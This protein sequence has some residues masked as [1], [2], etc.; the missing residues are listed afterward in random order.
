MPF[1]IGSG[2]GAGERPRSAGRWAG[3]RLHP[4]KT[5]DRP[6][7]QGLGPS[8]PD[9]PRTWRSLQ[10]PQQAWIGLRQ[11]TTPRAATTNPTR[12]QPPPR[13]QLLHTAP[14][15]VLRDPRRTRHR[16]DPATPT[17]PRLTRRP[18]PT[19]TLVQLRTQPRKTLRNLRLIDHPTRYD[20]RTPTSSHTALNRRLNHSEAQRCPGR[21]TSGRPGRRDQ[22]RSK[23]SRF[24]T[25]T[26]AA[27]K[28]CTN[29]S[30]A[31]SL[32]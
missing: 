30:R 4:D 21:P 16:S 31:S 28:S 27:T 1:Q 7:H 5:R 6:H 12:L 8:L 2:A 32:A 13:R 29:F 19:L 14:H 26:H 18:Q 20:S 9:P 10:V 25:L 3:T 22:V 15:R 23:R 24:M 11:R 17:R